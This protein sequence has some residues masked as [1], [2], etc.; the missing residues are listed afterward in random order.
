MVASRGPTPGVGSFLREQ[1]AR[2]AAYT[3]PLKSSFNLASNAT[4]AGDHPGNTARVGRW[5]PPSLAGGSPAPLVGKAAASVVQL[6]STEEPLKPHRKGWPS[7]LP[8]DDNGLRGSG[9]VLVLDTYI[10]SSD[11][12]TGSANFNSETPLVLEA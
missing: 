11:G 4:S 6:M 10:F 8:K 1:R 2:A 12:A 9:S 7:F 5:E 3:T